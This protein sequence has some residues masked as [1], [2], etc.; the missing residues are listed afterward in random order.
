[1]FVTPIV[2][3]ASSVFLS[4]KNTG[5]GNVLFQIASVYGIAKTF[6]RI[7]DFTRVVQFG[8]TLRMRFGFHH[9]DTIFRHCK[10]FVF[11]QNMFVEVDEREYKIVST[12]IYHRLRTSTE[13]LC[14]NGYLE[15]PQYF[16]AYASELR[17]LFSPD[18]ESF[19]LIQSKYPELFDP[20]TTPVSIHVR[21]GTDSN[22]QCGLTYYQ[23]AIEYIQARVSNPR[24][25][26][27]SDGEVGDL[28]VPYIRVQGHEDYIDL[29]VMS[30][31]THNITTYST[32]SWWGAFLNRN[33]DKIVTYPASASAFISNKNKA[34][35]E[36]LQRNYFLSAVCIE[37]T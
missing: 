36:E 4:P 33:A 15:C 7:P 6:N 13:N 23:H 29:W 9:N 14:L 24:F 32:F 35:A 3:A 19:R 8:E 27:V 21:Q 17:T 30:L 18:V 22:T 1:M 34:T 31:C 37:D 26:V 20:S 12:N 5:L 25:F 11:R 10:Y 2:T 28:G 16:S